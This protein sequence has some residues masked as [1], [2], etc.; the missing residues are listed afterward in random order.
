[1]SNPESE[2]PVNTINHDDL[3]RRGARWVI[4]ALLVGATAAFVSF[5]SSFYPIEEWLF[6]RYAGYWIACSFWSAGCVSSGYALVRRLSGTALPSAERLCLSFA[7]GVVLFYLAM[8]VLGMIHGL[9]RVTFFALP[10]AMMAVG[11]K[12]L[13]RDCQQRFRRDRQLASRRQPVSPV[14]VAIWIFGLAVLAM[15]YFKM[16]TPENVQFDA[17]W[18]HL[19]LA[20]QYAHL[21]FIPRFAEGWTVATNPHLASLL[22][23]WA[24]RVF[25]GRWQPSHL[26]SA[27]WYPAL[28]HAHPG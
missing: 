26:P 10:L 14:H 19:A 12:P 21:G 3:I 1:M 18:K 7:A 28:A 13:W 8:N 15:I 16:L 2:A 11:A 4:P 6:W 17:R 20:E 9:H 24:F 25:S 27:S 22:F 5:Y 23:A